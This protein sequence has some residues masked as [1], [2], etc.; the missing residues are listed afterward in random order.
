SGDWL[1]LAFPSSG[2]SPPSNGLV[3]AA[4]VCELHV[5]SGVVRLGLA[6]HPRAKLPKGGHP[7]AVGSSTRSPAARLPSRRRP[8]LLPSRIRDS[9]RLHRSCIRGPG[10]FFCVVT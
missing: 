4:A 6:P 5:A 1:A 2:L 3:G 8:L 10:R 7:W 9:R